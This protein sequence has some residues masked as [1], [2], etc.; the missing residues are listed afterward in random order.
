QM[1]ATNRSHRETVSRLLPD[2]R[3]RFLAEGERWS[4]PGPDHGDAGEIGDRAARN[5]R[6]HRRRHELPGEGSGLDGEG[7]D[8]PGRA[9]REWRKIVETGFVRQ[10]KGR[11]LLAA[12]GMRL[13]D[14]GDAGT[15]RP[16]VAGDRF[17]RPDAADGTR[18][19]SRD[20]RDQSLSPDRSRD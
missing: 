14:S 10:G 6:G 1:V 8:H 7:R 11:E 9:E 13:A 4:D 5:Q 15:L 20:L 3:L 17:S 19:R 16:D 12:L 2:R 18:S